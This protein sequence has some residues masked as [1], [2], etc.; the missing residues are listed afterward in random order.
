M[1]HLNQQTNFS[2][3]VKRSASVL[4]LPFVLS[5]CGG[6]DVS[7]NLAI[8]APVVLNDTG[9]T[10]CADQFEDGQSCTATAVTHP[11][12]DADLGRDVND[13][14]TAD[15]SAGFSFTNTGSGCVIDN[16]TGLVWELKSADSSSLSANNNTYSWYDSSRSYAAGD[17]GLENGGT[18]SAPASCDTQAYIA[19]INQTAMCGFNDWRLPS[20]AE[21]QS[22]VD[23]SQDEPGPMIDS[24]YF[25]NTHNPD[26]VHRLHRDWYWSSQTAAGYANYAWAV[27]FNTGGDTQM[28]K[29]TPQLI[30]LVRGGL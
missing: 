9:V 16:I 11:R 28:A 7:S 12:Q 24:Y 13:N 30:R 15:G 10:L 20:R 21:L 2:V 19:A 22:I 5:A 6:D 27:S 26:A 17:L 8:I 3:M 1:K 25:S 23:Y 29:H 18:C 4:F 14:N